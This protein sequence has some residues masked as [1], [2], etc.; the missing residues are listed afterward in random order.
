[1]LLNNVHHVDIVS[2]DAAAHESLLWPP[3]GQS[4]QVLETAEGVH[5]DRPL[6]WSGPQL[7]QTGRQGQHAGPHLCEVGHT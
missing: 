2:A 5:A 6:L 3:H 1:M 4:G 7:L